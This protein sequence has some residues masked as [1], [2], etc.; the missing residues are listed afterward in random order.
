MQTNWRRSILV[1]HFIKTVH[2]NPAELV[3]VML[4]CDKCRLKVNLH[5][6]M[7]IFES[8]I[9]AWLILPADVLMTGV[10][11]IFLYSVKTLYGWMVMWCGIRHKKWKK[12]QKQNVVFP[13]DKT[14]V[15]SATIINQNY[16]LLKTQATTSQHPIRK[17]KDF[18][19]QLVFDWSWSERKLIF[20]LPHSLF[21][22]SACWGPPALR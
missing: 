12:K 5:V 2:I 4:I 15:E 14:L 22:T 18:V 21:Q 16:E 20:T 3:Y 6:W 11:W 7:W 10:K 1:L 8:R 9:C 17:K 13:I 19:H